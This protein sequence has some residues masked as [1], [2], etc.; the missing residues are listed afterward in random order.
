VLTL[1]AVSSQLSALSES[2]EG[3]SAES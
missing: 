2:A 1:V 3:S